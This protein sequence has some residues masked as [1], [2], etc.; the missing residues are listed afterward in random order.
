MGNAA[1]HLTTNTADGRAERVRFWIRSGIMGLDA[2]SIATAKSAGPSLDEIIAL[3]EERVAALDAR[4]VADR[5]AQAALA[6]A[7]ARSG[8]Y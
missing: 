8:R 4:Q 3:G 1:K 6:N 5:L 7:K 2:L